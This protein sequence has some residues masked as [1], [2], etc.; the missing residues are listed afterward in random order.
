MVRMQYVSQNKD[1]SGVVSFELV[2]LS[3][4]PDWVE[5]GPHESRYIRQTRPIERGEFEAFLSV[6]LVLD[7]S[8]HMVDDRYQILP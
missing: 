2:T 1:L 3:D 5:D 6:P 4:R 8:D 7:L